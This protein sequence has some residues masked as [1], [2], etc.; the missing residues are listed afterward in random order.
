M[1]GLYRGGAFPTGGSVPCWFG[2]KTLFDCNKSTKYKQQCE[3]TGSMIYST[4]VS[5]SGFER[6]I[7]VLDLEVDNSF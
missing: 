6:M 2:D 7:D 4:F 3:R 5:D 1:V